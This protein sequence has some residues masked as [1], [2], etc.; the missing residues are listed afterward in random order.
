MHVGGVG[1]ADLEKL[2]VVH[3][4]A[5][6]AIGVDRNVGGKVRVALVARGL[7]HMGRH[8]VMDARD[9]G[10][11]LGGRD[12]RAKVSGAAGVARRRAAATV[13]A[14]TIGAGAGAGAPVWGAGS[15]HGAGGGENQRGR[16]G[17][18][19]RSK[20]RR[21]APIEARRGRSDDRRPMIAAAVRAVD[22]EW[23]GDAGWAF[24]AAG[25]RARRSA[26]QP[27]SGTQPVAVA[28]AAR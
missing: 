11:G 3:G 22:G 2:V 13:P 17:A 19:E 15:E 24:D 10:D 12:A 14:A 23:G 28:W 16:R 9:E 20:A 6:V 25:L 5:E 26:S 4:A 21:D 8:G 27:A 1:D 7:E 18:A